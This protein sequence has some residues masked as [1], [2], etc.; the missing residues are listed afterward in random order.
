MSASNVPKI[1][2]HSPIMILGAR[3]A[4]TTFSVWEGTSL[5]SNKVS[6]EIIVCQKFSYLVRVKKLASKNVYL[7][8]ISEVEQSP[9]AALV[10][11]EYIVRNAT[12][13]IHYRYTAMLGQTSALSVLHF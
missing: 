5:S 2:I 7:L 4:L 9:N 8:I 12:K 1:S 10:T 6:G 11:Q 3:H 13:A